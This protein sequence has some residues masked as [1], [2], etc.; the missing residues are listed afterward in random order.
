M[1]RYVLFILIFFTLVFTQETGARYLIITH[2]SFYEA[3]Q[4]LV[5]WKHRKGLSTK[6]VKLSDIGSSTS[7]I[8]NYIVT[9]YDTWE[10][11]PEFLLLVGAPN[12]LPF[13]YYGPGWHSYYSDNYYTSVDA[14]VY[15]EILS[16]RLTVHSVSEAQAVVNKILSYEMTPNISD[17]LW[18]I[19]ACLIVREDYDYD[20]SIYWSDINHAKDLM[21][22]HGYNIIDTLSWSGGDDANDVIAAVNEGRAFVLYRGS[23]LN[24]WYPP[25]SVNPD[26]TQNGTKLPIVLSITCRTIGTSS[27]P[28]TAEGWLLTG[29]PTVPRGAAGYFATTTAISNGAYLRSA[30]CKGFFNALFQEGKRTFGEACEGARMNVYNLYGSESE[31]RGFTTL[32]DPAMTIWTAIPHP[33]A[34]SHDTLLSLEDDSLLVHVECHDVPLESALVCVLLDTL[35]YEYGYT[36]SEGSIVFNFDT[37]IPGYMH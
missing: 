25:F 27:T 22:N 12:Y 35:V 3:I 32:G 7:Q 10:T 2:D 34:V 13:Y 18:F 28:A 30:V 29:T 14:D 20:D 37:L 16:G 23:G 6:V 19:N 1:K 26:Q 5:Q 8:R 21:R 31:Y 17:S 15:N 4:P 9:A 36:T 24:N 11:P 33:L